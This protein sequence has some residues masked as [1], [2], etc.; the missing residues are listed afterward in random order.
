M[1]YKETRSQLLKDN[2]V[3]SACLNI[4]LKPGDLL[5]IDNLQYWQHV[6]LCVTAL[7]FIHLTVIVY[8]AYVYYAYV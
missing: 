8:Y 2:K 1:K 3:K 6:C 7:I 4:I 5:F